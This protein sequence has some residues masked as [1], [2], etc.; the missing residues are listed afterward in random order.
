MNKFWGSSVQ[1][2]I[3]VTNTVLYT[4]KLLREQIL[5]VLTTKKEMMIR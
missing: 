1:R 2:V 3:I 5:N 4:Y